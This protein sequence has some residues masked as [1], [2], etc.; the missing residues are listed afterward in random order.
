MATKTAKIR[1]K[2]YVYIKKHKNFAAKNSVWK[3]ESKKRSFFDAK[4]GCLHNLRFDAVF[5]ETRK[6]LYILVQKV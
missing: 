6:K 3:A 5:S 1:R 4:N 2:Y